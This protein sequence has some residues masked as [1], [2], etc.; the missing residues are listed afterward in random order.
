MSL[1]EQ[2]QKLEIL[3]REVRRLRAIPIGLL[4]S[5]VRRTDTSN[6]SAADALKAVRQIGQESLSDG[7]QAALGQ[8]KQ[9]LE[10]DG[11]DVDWTRRQEKRKTRW[12]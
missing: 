1:A 12:G 5:G 7:M 11:S 9:S 8:A 2:I 10:A 4:Q 3:Q 6:V